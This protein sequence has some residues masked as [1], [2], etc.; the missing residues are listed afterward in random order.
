MIEPF[1]CERVAAATEL[2]VPEVLARGSLAGTDQDGEPERWALYEHLE[3]ESPDQGDLEPAVRHQFVANAG[4]LLGRLHATPQESFGLETT[5]ATDVDV[6]GI[7]RAS[8]GGLTVCA[9]DGWH[10]MDSGG[11][12]EALCSRVSVPLAGDVDCLAVLTHG[13][14]QPSNL[15]V[16]DTGTIT[17]VLDW[18]NAHI[19]HA[20]YALARAECRF[21]DLEWSAG[22]LKRGERARLRQQ[23]REGYARKGPLDVTDEMG[24]QL[25]W[26]KGLWLAQSLANYAHVARSTRGREQLWRQCRRLLE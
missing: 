12:L 21:V 17:G 1:V 2:P 5:T 14:Y 22:R 13:D 10:A 11:A 15:L 24:R 16:D 8:G 26:Y 4:R 18:G 3:G 19:T 7:A 25:R 23:F 9:P 6:G 20:A